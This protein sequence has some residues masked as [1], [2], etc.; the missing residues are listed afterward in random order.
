M[1]EVVMIVILF[2]LSKASTGFTAAEHRG[3]VTAG[4]APSSLANNVPAT[5]IVDL[6]GLTGSCR[7]GRPRCRVKRGSGQTD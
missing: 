3:H 6:T 5:A 1:V 7:E 2:V 4:T